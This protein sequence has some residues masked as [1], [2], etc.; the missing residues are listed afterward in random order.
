MDKY[1]VRDKKGD[2]WYSHKDNFDRHSVSPLSRSEGKYD[3][4]RVRA[5]RIAV[6]LEQE[7]PDLSP[8]IVKKLKNRSVFTPPEEVYVVLDALDGGLLLHP[9]SY[10]KESAE[11]LRTYLDVDRPI[12]TLRYVLAEDEY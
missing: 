6:F 12:K 2:C 7:R 8:F 3:M 11:Q 5:Y 1:I 4:P 10:T 9:P